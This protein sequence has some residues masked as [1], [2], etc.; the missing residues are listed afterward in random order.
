MSRFEFSIESTK[1]GA[2]TKGLELFY[3]HP[4]IEIVFD[5]PE[6]KN[7]L[8]IVAQKVACGQMF[9]RG[10]LYSDILEDPFQVTFIEIPGGM[11]IILPDSEGELSRSEMNDEEFK[12]QFSAPGIL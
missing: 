7:L 8:V 3:D 2:F 10:C 6:A 11:R 12:R 4:D 1:G 9:K 5:F